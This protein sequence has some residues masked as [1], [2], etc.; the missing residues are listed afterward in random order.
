MDEVGRDMAEFLHAAL[1]APV[2]E[3]EREL[4]QAVSLEVEACELVFSL[5]EA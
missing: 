2:D 1:G 4:S 5:G 3:A